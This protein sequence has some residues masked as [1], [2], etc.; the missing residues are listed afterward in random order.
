MHLL[1]CVVSF[2]LWSKK[3]LLSLRITLLFS[4]V[5]HCC[6]LAINTYSLLPFP[7]PFRFPILFLFQLFSVQWFPGCCFN[8]D[9]VFFVLLSIKPNVFLRL[10][11]TVAFVCV[12]VAIP[13][14]P[15]LY[16]EWDLVCIIIIVV[17]VTMQNP[18]IS[19]WQ[20]YFWRWGSI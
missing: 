9:S 16:P 15:C 5:A 12:C 3:G 4:T 10:V 13:Y 20:Y 8:M 11:W 19:T 18:A 7:Y 6:V 17:N 2:Q 14:I 1:N